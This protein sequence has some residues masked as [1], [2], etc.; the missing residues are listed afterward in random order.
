MA[1]NFENTYPTPTPYGVPTP[2][3]TPTPYGVPTPYASPSPQLPTTYKVKK[4]GK[5]TFGYFPPATRVMPRVSRKYTNFS[6]NK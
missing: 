3:P 6:K 2:Y 5:P 4:G 1:L